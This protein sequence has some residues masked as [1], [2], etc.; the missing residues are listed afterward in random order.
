MV[1]SVYLCKI[2]WL[3][4]VVGEADI[5]AVTKTW[6]TNTT[7]IKLSIRAMVM[8]VSLSFIPTL[9]IFGS[10][11]GALAVRNVSVFASALEVS[12]VT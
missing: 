3:V 8:T 9:A 5:A 4:S 12:V 7:S 6:M 1:S 11:M 10:N 2:R